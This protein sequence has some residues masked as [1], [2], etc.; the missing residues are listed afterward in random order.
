MEIQ[1][2]SGDSRYEESVNE[3]TGRAMATRNEA[4]KLHGEMITHLT[5]GLRECA[6]DA[7]EKAIAGKGQ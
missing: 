7:L 1:E 3:T 5:E 2:V 6:N 4:K